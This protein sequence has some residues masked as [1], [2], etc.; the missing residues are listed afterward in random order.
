LIALRAADPDTVTALSCGNSAEV[1]AQVLAGEAEIGFVEGPKVP[2]GVQAREVARDELAVVVAPSHTWARRQRVRPA[3]LARTPL[4]S[5]EAGTGTRQAWEQAVREQLDI[6]LAAPILEVSSTTAIKAATMGGIGPAVLS[7]R[8]VTAE[9]RPDRMLGD[10]TPNDRFYVRSHA[11]TPRLDVATWTLRVEGGAVHEPV[12]YTYDDLWNG[13][14]HVSVV[15][16]IECA[17]NRRVLFGEEAGAPDRGPFEL[18]T[19]D[20]RRGPGE[21]RVVRVEYRIDEGPW[22]E[23]SIESPAPPGVWVRWQFRWDPEPGEHTLRVRATDDQ[24]NT[25]PDSSSWNEL[26]YLQT[27]ELAH[28]VRVESGTRLEP[29]RPASA[30]DSRRSRRAA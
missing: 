11:P 22:L 21:N 14:P 24:G 20:E 16:T 9:F 18:V 8:A 12:T 19:R 3:E 27:A 17:G 15:R 2:G 13:F 26:G 28:P 4:V 25:Q 6:D 23:A 30:T 10:L 5:R 29:S 7:V 1:A